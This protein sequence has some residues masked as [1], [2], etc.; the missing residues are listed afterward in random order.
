[1][2]SKYITKQGDTFD[3]ISKEIYGD[4]KYAD[5]IIKSNLKYIGTLIFDYGTELIIPEVDI[6]EE[7][8]LPPWRE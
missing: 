2:S 4:E 5:S 7:T 6:K 1:M 8:T 3:I